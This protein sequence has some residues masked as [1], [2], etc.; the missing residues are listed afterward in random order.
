MEAIMNI[1]ASTSAWSVITLQF[2]SVFTKPTAQ[3]FLNLITGWILC[4]VRRTI[5]GIFP[6]ADP[7]VKHAHDAYHRFFSKARWGVGDLWRMLA[8]TLIG[9]LR[10]KGVV[11]LALDDTLFHHS[12]KKINGAGY[13]RDA[14]RSSQHSIV[15]AW[16]LNLALLTLQVQPPW[17]GEPLGLPVT[18]RLHRKKDRTL[19]ELAQDMMEEI[20]QWMPERRF[21]LVGD[22]FYACLAGE[23]LPQTSLI[24]RMK[25]NAKLYDLPP[26]TQTKHRG[27]P[28]KRGRLL[29][30]PEKMAAQVKHWQ[31][32]TF[33]QRGKTAKRLVYVRKVLWYA[34]SHTPVLLVISRDPKG[35][36]KDDFLFTTDVSMTAAEVLECFNDRWPIEDT[37]KNTKQYLGG[38][39]PQVFKEQG[40]ERAAALSLWLYSIIWLW[41]LR[42]KPSQRIY[43]VWPWYT[44]K[45]APSFADALRNLR[46]QL[47]MDRFKLMFDVSAVHDKKFEFLVEALAS[48]A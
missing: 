24:S 19:I 28:R 20:S 7:L 25:R 14:V 9:Q 27:R 1:T 26:K 48:A 35:K 13:W 12:G 31:K 38:Q 29:P 30:N 21:R 43:W 32:I 46:Y 34:V 33:R 18:M 23:E 39:E 42:Q 4:T 6:F 36:E 17:G 45:A 16:G 22:G 47:W 3:I 5:T 8:V 40:P 10:P 15:Y 44:H 11:L 2:L 41:Y 37:F